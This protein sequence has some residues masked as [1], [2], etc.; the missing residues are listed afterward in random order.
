MRWQ[1][2]DFPGG[3]NSKRGGGTT[4]YLF[5]FFPKTMKIEEIW[6]EDSPFPWMRQFA[7]GY[8]KIHSYRSG[9]EDAKRSVIYIAVEKVKTPPPPPPRKL[10]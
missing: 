5:F 3:A 7:I 6:Q 8:L 9:K 4:Y 2:Q 1:I 10:I